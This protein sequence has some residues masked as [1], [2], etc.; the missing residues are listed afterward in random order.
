ML[1]FAH[2]TQPLDASLVPGLALRGELAYFPGAQP[3]RAVF[4]E[5]QTAMQPF[6]PDGISNLAGFQDEYAA[7]LSNNPWLELFPAVLES[8]VPM[9]AGEDWILRD[10]SGLAL[11]VDRHFQSSWELY[12]L[13]GGH[14]LK[15]FGTW[16]GF[17]FLPMSA[18]F[19]ERH[20]A[21]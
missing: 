19:A 10:G 5:K 20:V 6:V 7:A 8:L 3:L 14:P 13:A 2:R 11:P 21:L 1:N 17:A 9:R 12:S 16:D 18:W 4:K 15:I